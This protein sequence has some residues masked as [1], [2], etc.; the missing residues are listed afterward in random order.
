MSGSEQKH[1][2]GKTGAKQ[3]RNLL[4]QSLGSQEGIVL[5]GKL[6]DELLVFVQPGQEACISHLLVRK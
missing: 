6:L 4:D 5:L 1:T 3:T 2:L